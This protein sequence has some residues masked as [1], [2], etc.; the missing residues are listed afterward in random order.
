MT[1]QSPTSFARLAWKNLKRN[2]RRNLATGIAIAAGFAAFLLAAGYAYRIDRYLRTYT[3]YALRVGHIGI[4][5]TDG[6]ENF[7][8]RPREYSI[9]P[10]LQKTIESALKASD[11]VNFFGKYLP[12]SGLVGNG[13]KTF[14]FFGNGIDTNVEKQIM[15]SPELLEY[16]QNIKRA[17]YGRGLWN[18][19]ADLGGV[20]LS[21]GLAKLL[22]K[23]KVHDDLPPDTKPYV[24]DCFSN[25]QNEDFAKDTN[26]QLAAGTWQGMMNA[27][28][29][30]VVQHYS[31]GL[32]ETNTSSL[33][34]TLA[35]M[36]KLYDTQDVA[37]YSVWVHD[38]IKLHFIV[39]HLRK[40]L[41]AH[42]DK[43][44]ILPWHNARLSPYYN[45][46]IQFIVTL[47]SFI[48]F[49]LTLVIVL[50]IFNSATMTVLERG[51]EI[52]M[53]RSLG[54]T[55]KRIKQ[56]FMLESIALTA[57]SLVAG[58]IVAMITMMI[59]NRAGIVFNPPGISGGMQLALSPNA[60]IAAAGAFVIF[61][62]AIV[63]TWYAT[64]LSI[65]KT[66][67]TLLSGGHR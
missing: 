6:V 36:Q 63:S 25:L 27:V 22:G 40:A 33:A 66:I 57:I 9:D 61:L 49:V 24:A 16:I 3:I 29:G 28:D 50:S 21:S 17:E 34:T 38:P 1:K 52:G 12:G 11:E 5:R 67:P 59:V 41:E 44:D 55:K 48:G 53:L 37:Y 14:P 43:I 10:G 65:H 60:L 35:Q 18:Y 19:P 39:R 31:T 56:I 7:V 13:C 47:V 42:R 2:R 46:T 64:H 30:E 23:T 4:Y 32:V 20:A 54:F 15:E 8:L 26:V 58:G 45:G 62:L 51:Q